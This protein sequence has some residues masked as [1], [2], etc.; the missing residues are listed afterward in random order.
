MI[1]ISSN[2]LGYI[3]EKPFYGQHRGKLKGIY[4]Y[5]YS[6][7]I[8]YRDQKNKFRLSRRQKAILIGT[9]LGDGNL[10]LHGK[11]CRLFIKHSAS[12]SSLA[13]WKRKEFEG[14]TKMN[15]NF[16]RQRVKDKMYGFCQFVTLT[17]RDFGVY[18]KTF[19]Q[20]KRKVIPKDIDNILKETLSLAV[21]I[22]DDGAKDSVGMTIQ[23]HSFSYQAVKR[24]QKCLMSNFNLLVS[25][26]KNK[27]RNILYIPKS[28]IKRLYRLV[29]RYILSEYKYKFP[30]TP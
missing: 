10:T 13:E 28:Q 22:M 15:L 8:K 20:N 17:H 19:Y 5:T 14:I 1:V 30:L 6:M 24:L 9:I 27:N 3:G 4:I 23:T 26:R 2:K 21:W 29:D 18:Q 16:F 7:N 12:Q 11:D 25:I